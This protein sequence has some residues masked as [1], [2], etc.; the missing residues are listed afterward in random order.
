MISGVDFPPAILPGWALDLDGP[1]R[2]DAWWRERG[3]AF[4]DG[5]LYRYGHQIDIAAVVAE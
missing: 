5:G 4:T 3:A 2:A 1:G